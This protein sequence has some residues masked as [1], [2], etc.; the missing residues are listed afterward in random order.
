MNVKKLPTQKQKTEQDH[1]KEMYV[2]RGKIKMLDEI[3]ESLDIQQKRDIVK[4]EF[5][6]QRWTDDELWFGFTLSEKAA[7]LINLIKSNA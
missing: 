2:A 7:V 5:P 1:L 6:D 4:K 3:F